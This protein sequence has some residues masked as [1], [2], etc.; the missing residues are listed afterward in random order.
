MFDLHTLFTYTDVSY[1]MTADDEAATITAAQAG[2]E[3]ATMA[4]LRAYG[5]AMRSA[6]GT[7]VGRL[8]LEERAQAYEDAQMEAVSAVLALIADHDAD[9]SP[10]LAGRV[11]Q[12]LK[13]ALGELAR[14]DA[15][16]NIPRRTL[17]RFYGVLR[18][19]DGDI[20]AAAQLAP[21]MG[22]TRANFDEVRAAVRETLNV[23]GA[24]DDA[25][26]GERMLAAPIV[27]E[28]YRPYD[29]VEDAL[30]VEVA[31]AAVDDTE[32]RI[33][34]MAYGFTEPDPV[35]DAEIGHRIG[36][37][38]LKVLRTRNGALDKMRKTLGVTPVA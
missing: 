30:M 10:R 18:A 14:L 34:E 6:V 4:L 24:D 15:A 33:C 11:V 12:A 9:E 7:F 36:M 26:E 37:N 19:A 8:P 21:S 38:R 35:P 23:T 5:P 29:E 3:D 17:D 28:V 2:D 31:F 1:A 32:A 13:G 27:S 20:D 16:L 25:P 22:M